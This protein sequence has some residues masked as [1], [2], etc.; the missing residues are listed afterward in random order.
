MS[1]DTKRLSIGKMLGSVNEVYRI[2]LYQRTYNWGKDQWNDLWEDLIKLEGEE[3]HFLGSVITIGSERKKG[4]SYFEVVDGQQ[5]ITT[6]LI[7]LTAIR[8]LAE[9]IDKDRAGY[10]NTYF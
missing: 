7:M 4:F 5:R 6:T 10:I 8:D 2:P 9:E 3:T 1:I